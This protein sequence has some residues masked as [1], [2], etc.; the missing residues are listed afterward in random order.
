LHFSFTIFV[1]TLDHTEGK[2]LCV[3]AKQASYSVETFLK[4]K[5]KGTVATE[6]AAETTNTKPSK[7][8]DTPRKRIRSQNRRFDM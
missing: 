3:L 5:T 8:A 4:L 2:R 6:I 7:P 1:E